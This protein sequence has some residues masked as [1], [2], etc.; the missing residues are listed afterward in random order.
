MRRIP[1]VATAVLSL[2]V[3][4]MAPRAS[5]AEACLFDSETAT[6]PYLC[7]PDDS[8]LRARHARLWLSSD[9]FPL[10]KIEVAP[11]SVAYLSDQEEFDGTTWAVTGTLGESALQAR[12][13]TA[14]SATVVAVSPAACFYRG[15]RFTSKRLCFPPGPLRTYTPD[16]F[17]FASSVR[18]P[19]TLSATAFTDF[20]GRG[21]MATFRGSLDGRALET[22]DMFQRIRSVHIARQKPPPVL[23]PLVIPGGDAYDLS[24]IFRGHMLP[25]AGNPYVGMVFDADPGRDIEVTYGAR[26][27]VRLR[28][29][30]ALVRMLDPISDEATLLPDKRTRYY[31]VAIEL[32]PD[33][34]ASMVVM[35]VADDH[36]LI[37]A[38][39]WL[40][41]P[42]DVPV[43]TVLSVR[44]A[45]SSMAVRAVSMLFEVGP[46]H[47]RSVRAAH[48]ERIALKNC[49]AVPPRL[50]TPTPQ[51]LAPLSG[52]PSQTPLP[53]TPIPLASPP[54]DT[55]LLTNIGVSGN[56]MAVAA[57]QRAC[58]IPLMWGRRPL[59]LPDKDYCVSRAI[60]IV[61]MYQTLFNDLWRLDAFT[62]VID[63]ILARGTT[64]L[65]ATD[66]S[67]E[68]ALVDAVRWQTGANDTRRADALAA[69]H[70]ANLVRAYSVVRTMNLEGATA[71]GHA[72]QS[73]TSGICGGVKRSIATM[74]TA[75]L[76][77]YDLDLQQY[78]PLDVRPR[79]WR[80]GQWV[81]A[82][83]AFEITRVQAG[84]LGRQRQAVDTAHA[85][86]R[87]YLLAMRPAALRTAL[88]D[89]CPEGSGYTVRDFLASTGLSAAMGIEAAVRDNDEDNEILLVR[90]RGAPVAMLLG[91]IPRHGSLEAEITLMVSAPAN[92]LPPHGDGTVRGAASAALQ[93]FLKYCKERGM[94][95]VRV[96]AVT[97]P[98]AAIHQRAG[99]RLLDDLTTVTTTPPG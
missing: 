93:E 16:L 4:G 86:Q 78:T 98:S 46:S 43:D 99:F 19:A 55:V 40:D 92:V 79:V 76:G 75:A 38:T 53:H 51:P 9:H 65:R 60:T 89:D 68:Q 58:A 29:Q 39:P 49:R 44:N 32:R 61:T 91:T 90:Y 20:R 1:Q 24:S 56:P 83:D 77:R 84:Q 33:K 7:V 18:V 80:N 52:P 69:F 73:S 30:S 11:G 34:S 71:I 25:G 97:E 42:W 72:A 21:S 23:G 12:G 10:R 62:A 96:E 87:D 82:S 54:S 37:Q 59:G 64:G 14:K 88:G 13:I 15:T 48:C 31:V 27:T 81:D 47:D 8:M 70:H 41:I 26:V 45:S 50:T 6:E 67:S 17:A 35:Q 57:A 36:D 74:R 3:L 95:A 63:N 66:A 94:T 5:H 85:W 28:K 22:A 2:L